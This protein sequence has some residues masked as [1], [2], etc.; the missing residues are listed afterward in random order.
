MEQSLV[1][2]RGNPYSYA[3]KEE[4]GSRRAG[5]MRL[6]VWDNTGRVQ[7]YKIGNKEEGMAIV[8]AKGFE[9][10]LTPPAPPPPPEP[11]KAASRRKK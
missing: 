2:K 6:V 1:E 7:S 3:I 4:T 11:V 5:A 9:E 8:A 10:L